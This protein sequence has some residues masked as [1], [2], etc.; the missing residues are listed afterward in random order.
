MLTV[1]IPAATSTLA[2]IEAMRLAAGLV[3]TDESRDVE[4]ALLN[5]R[6]SADIAVACRVAVGNGNDPTL[7]QET[8]TQVFRKLKRR[9]LVL[10][11][12]H[13]IEIVSVLVDHTP[14]STADFYVESEAGMI[15]RLSGD[16]PVDW[17][18]R[19]ATVIYKAG[20][21]AVPADLEGAAMDLARIRLSEA[22]RDPLVK[23]ERVDVPDV[24]ERETSYWVGSVPGAAQAKGPVPPEILVK[25]ARY[26]NLVIS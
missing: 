11:R 7:R 12:R 4:L 6:I 13:N 8:L 19:S 25:L 18:G 17:R 9:S 24:M 26:M 23:G 15:F 16:Q 20:F 10:A 21:D 22:R 2:S 14:I 5:K 1:T 3:A